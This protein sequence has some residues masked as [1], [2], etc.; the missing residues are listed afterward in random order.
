MC[1]KD[2]VALYLI[3]CT[4][5]LVSEFILKCIG[6]KFSWQQNLENTFGLFVEVTV[7]NVRV[8]KIVLAM[9]T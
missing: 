3:F 6:N 2:G 1:L 5:C 9:C 4:A 7:E 8:Q